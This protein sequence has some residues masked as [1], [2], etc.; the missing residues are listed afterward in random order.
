MFQMFGPPPPPGMARAGAPAGQGPPP[1]AQG[2]PGGPIPPGAIPMFVQVGPQ[3]V[4]VNQ[5]TV[6]TRMEG[7]NEG[8]GYQPSKYSTYGIANIIRRL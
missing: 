4:S 1:N 2:Q 3:S 8:G 5:I 7:E 6:E